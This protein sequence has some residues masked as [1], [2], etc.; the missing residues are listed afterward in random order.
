ML[1]PG[2]D[3]VVVA[4]AEVNRVPFSTLVGWLSAAANEER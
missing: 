3:Y 2:T 4:S 1:T